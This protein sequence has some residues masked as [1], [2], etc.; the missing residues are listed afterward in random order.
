VSQNSLRSLKASSAQTGCDKHE[1]DARK[2]AGHKTEQ[3]RR[4]A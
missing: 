3:R 2:R 4:L 1:D